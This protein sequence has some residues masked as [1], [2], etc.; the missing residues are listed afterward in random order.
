MSEKDEDTRSRIDFAIE[1]TT[2]EVYVSYLLSLR[3]RTE[4]WI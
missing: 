1:K 2:G 3:T 4:M